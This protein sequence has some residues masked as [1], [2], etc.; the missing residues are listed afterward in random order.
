MSDVRHIQVRPEDDG[1]RLDRW[2][3]KCV[4]ELP[5]MLAQKLIR[6][7]AIRINGKRGKADTRLA[8]GQDVRLP[9]LEDKK[10]P[11]PY[12]VS[13]EEAALIKSLVIYDDGDLVAI[14]KPP[15]LATQGG[16]AE[17]RHIDGMAAA[18]TNKRDM[19]PRLVHRLDKATSGV[20]LMAR[21]PEAVRALGKAFRDRTIRKTYWALTSG[22]PE[23]RDG[24]IKAPVGKVKGAI[25][26]KMMIDE[27]DGKMAVTD[28]IKLERMGS[29]AAFVIFRP[30]TGRTHQI[31]VHAA[32]VLGCPVLG[33]HKYGGHNN[34]ELEALDIVNRLHLHA[35]R[36][37]F[38]HP[39]E[40][41]QLEITAPLPAELKKSWR[42]MGFDPHYKSDPFENS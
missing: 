22:V 16:G 15:G 9:P 27:E 38:D 2:L 11:R 20:L 29:A 17:K 18:L 19:R 40:K 31:R 41:K 26:D 24:T 39:L 3:K 14:N 32:A 42:M 37:V 33:D 25:K 30:R 12:E 10:Q 8:T 13:P 7:G 34:E 4:P 28:F 23:Q 5:Y 36:I 1:Q 35:Q 6:K 21:S